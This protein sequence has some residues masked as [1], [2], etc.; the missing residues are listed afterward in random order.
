M[1][2]EARILD[3]CEIID[4][5]AYRVVDPKM[6]K[7]VYIAGPITRGV[8]AENIRQGTEAA[9]ELMREGYAPLCPML[10]CYMGGPSPE[11]LPAGT[12]H[13]DWMGTDLPW[14]AKADALLRLPG[15]SVGADLEV[16]CAN[17]HGVPVFHSISDLNARLER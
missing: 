17:K 2:A 15:E 6:R 12:T 16:A 9:L 7:A 3:L 5:F 14:V 10:T 4:G 11:V 13:G 1:A 8:L